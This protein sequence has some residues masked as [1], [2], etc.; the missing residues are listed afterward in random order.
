MTVLGCMSS[1][2]VTKNNNNT[3]KMEFQEPISQEL[4]KRFLSNL[5][6]E[7]WY[8][9][10]LKYVS[11]VEVVPIVL[12]EAEISVSALLSWPLTL[13]RVS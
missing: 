12:W 6:C 10:T 9:K 1:L 13:D 5:V 4:P 2:L 7:V 3:K 11:Y 8:M